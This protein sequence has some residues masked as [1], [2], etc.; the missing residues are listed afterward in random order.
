MCALAQGAKGGFK[1]AET[2]PDLGD[3]LITEIGG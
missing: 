1:P 3:L 2:Q